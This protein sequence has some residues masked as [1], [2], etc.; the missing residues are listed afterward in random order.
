MI[1]ECSLCDSGR[2]GVWSPATVSDM[3]VKKPESTILNMGRIRESSFKKP[4][5]ITSGV[6]WVGMC[7]WDLPGVAVVKNPPADA[8]DTCLIPGSGRSPE[9]GNGNPHQYS[10]LGNPMDRGAWGLQSMGSQK[11]QT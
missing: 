9:V 5:T 6:G 3:G 4:V 10:C 11:S 7:L 2:T 8:G 1:P